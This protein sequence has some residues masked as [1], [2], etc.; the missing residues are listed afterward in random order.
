MLPI[1]TKAVKTSPSATNRSLILRLILENGGMSRIDLASILQVTKASVT[2]LTNELIQNNI[3]YEKGTE[4][5][6]KKAA[7]GRRKILL[8]IN[9]ASRLAFGAALE[10]DSL[11]IG[12]T[13]LKGETLDKRRILLHEKSYHDILSCIVDEIEALKSLNCLN[14]SR[15]LG[16]GVC[17]GN[18]GGGVIAAPSIYDKLLRIKKDLA[19]AIDLPICV[20]TL[21]NGAILAQTLFSE[22]RPLYKNLLMLRYGDAIESGVLLN[23]E[24][25]LPSSTSDSKSQPLPNELLQ[26]SGGFAPMQCPNPDLQATTYTSYLDSIASANEDE[27][28]SARKLLLSALS[29]DIKACCT[30][31]CPEAVFAFG[32]FL[33]AENNLSW[34]NKIFETNYRQKLHL[35]IGVVTDSNVHLAACASAINEYFYKSGGFS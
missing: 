32:N 35:D 21:I 4:P 29:E 10:K 16:L 12:L 19:C 3:L 13:N 5:K 24:L 22:R 7:R 20:N 18:R 1:N 8:E 28:D 25:Y 27:R 11:V 26:Y 6:T 30:V 31:L 9:E 2:L 23:G 34:I 33:E 15:L 14:K 17:I